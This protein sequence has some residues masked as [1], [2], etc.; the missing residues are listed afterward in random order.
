M[1]SPNPPDDELRRREQELQAREHALRLRELE[2]ELYAQNQSIEPPVSP[3]VK[4]QP[5]EGR[6]NQQLRQ[7]L[8]VGKFLGIVIAVVVA[9]KIAAWLATVVLVGGVA[10][11]A[12]KLFFGGD[13]RRR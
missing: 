2:A 3:T 7:A 8:E 10:F 4:H 5:A 11:I 6:L 13:H 1:A 12:Y 9:A